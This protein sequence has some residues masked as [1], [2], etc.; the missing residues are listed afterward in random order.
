MDVSKVAVSNYSDWSTDFDQTPGGE[1]VERNPAGLE[2]SQ[3]LLAELP[4]ADWANAL[5]ENFRGIWEDKSAPAAPPLPPGVAR[6][7]ESGDAGT[8]QPEMSISPEMLPPGL[9]EQ[10]AKSRIDSLLTNKQI[11]YSDSDNGKYEPIVRESLEKIART[12]SGRATLE[13]VF[14]LA[15]NPR[16]NAVLN[17]IVED[18]TE[19]SSLD[20]TTLYPEMPGNEPTLIL[21]LHQDMIDKD[22]WTYRAAD[23]EQRLI[24][25]SDAT[26]NLYHEL[27]HASQDLAEKDGDIPRLENSLASE[28]SAVAATDIFAGEL[29]SITGETLGRRESYADTKIYCEGW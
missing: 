3:T 9:S 23:P 21:I 27:I 5:L 24:Q 16:Q 29:E 18:N 8:W 1:P 2:D 6:P 17:L 26:L 19:G 12:P 10:E 13:H 14:G 7:T 4:L 22:C 25:V 20:S 28:N 11:R 15:D